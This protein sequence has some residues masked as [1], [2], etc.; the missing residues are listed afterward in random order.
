MKQ[1]RTQ[2]KRYTMKAYFR[3]LP[4]FL[5][6][7]I[8]LMSCAT[9]PKPPLP[10][11][12]TDFGIAAESLVKSLLEKGV[13]VKV[14]N[15]PARLRVVAP[16]NNTS[17]HFDTALLTGKIR[18]ALNQSGKAVTVLNPAE[19]VDYT[20]SGKI[21]STYSRDRKSRQRTFTFQLALTD[22]RGTA[23]WEGEKEVTK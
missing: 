6:C 5:L 7:P 2:A 13:L 12:T 23:V 18:V 20:L 15:P 8:L 14:P 9:P 4:M 3:N 16:L 1:E 22:S 19:P 17:E 10:T 21:I 11:T